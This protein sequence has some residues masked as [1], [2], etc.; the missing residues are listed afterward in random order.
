MRP[1][2]L[3]TILKLVQTALLAALC[4]VCFTYLKISIPIPGGGNTSLHIGNAFC[5]LAALLLGGV[6]GGLAGAIGMTLADLLDPRYITS[7]PKTFL[8]K[9]CIGLIAGFVAHKIAKI[10]ANKDKKYW[11]RWAFLSSTAGLSFNV[12]FDPIIGYYYK[13]YILGINADLASIMQKWG[14]A[15]TL[16]N[17]I[18][19][20][21]LVT[22]LYV[23]LRPVLT[24]ASLM[25]EIKYKTKKE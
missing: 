4:F 10:S 11:I 24:K 3:S 19:S 12:I 21:I 23:A 7:A 9:L 20:V 5:V 16:V 1:R 15:T 8:M 17:A 13:R 2:L 25:P 6:Y 14:A 22:I 18:V